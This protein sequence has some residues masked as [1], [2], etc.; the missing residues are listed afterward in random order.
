MVFRYTH[1]FD[2]L[3]YEL[4]DSLLDGVFVIFKNKYRGGGGG[5][6]PYG[7]DSHNGHN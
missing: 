6:R 7:Q 1:V 3:N 5:G 2:H 4:T